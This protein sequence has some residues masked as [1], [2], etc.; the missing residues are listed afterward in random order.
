MTTRAQKNRHLGDFIVPEGRLELPSLTAHDFESCMVTN[1][2]TPAY[3]VYT[4][5]FS[6]INQ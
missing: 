6:Q 3:V 5:F 1:F 4:I 2:I